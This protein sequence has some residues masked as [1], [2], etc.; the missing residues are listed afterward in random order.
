MNFSFVLKFYFLFFI[1]VPGVF[2]AT[3]EQCYSYFTELVRSSNF[4]FSQWS[5]K[6]QKVNLVIDEDDDQTIRAKLLIDTH[7]TGTLGWVVYDKRKKELYDTT[8]EPDHPKELKFNFEYAKAQEYC[9]QGEVV[10]QIKNKGRSYFYK[11]KDNDFEKI[12][13]FIVN[14]DYIKIKKRL[15]DYSEASYET[16]NGAIVTGWI[17]NDALRKVDFVSSW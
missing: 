9:L 5:V 7:G 3:P 15:S 6:P 17:A 16:K 1:F 10:Y 8:I 13:L 4:P 12:D 11:Q 2:A 14:G